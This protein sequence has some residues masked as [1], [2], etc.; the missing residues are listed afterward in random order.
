MAAKPLSIKGRWRGLLLLLLVHCMFRFAVASD[1]IDLFRH[2]IDIFR[3]N[4]DIRRII[5]PPLKTQVVYLTQTL[6]LG[7]LWK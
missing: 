1:G 3:H 5:V 6:A 2:K 7:A 4:I